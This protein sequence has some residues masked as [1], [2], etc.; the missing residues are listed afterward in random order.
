MKIIKLLCFILAASII[1]PALAKKPKDKNKY[2]AYMVGASASFTD[3]L[4]YFTNIQ[5]VDSAAFGEKGLL[6][7]RAQYST[8]LKDFLEDNGIG[9][10]R[11]C[12]VYYNKK[13]K[14]LQKELTK[15]KQRYQKGNALILKDV[16]SN[17]NFKKAELYE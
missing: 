10:H 17:F 8:Q 11:T 13:K 4:V 1:I 5:Y 14:K 12:F 6:K 15:L 9:N 16:P 2:G 7:G 3:S